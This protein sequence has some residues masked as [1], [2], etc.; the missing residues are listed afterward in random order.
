MPRPR[1]KT[2]QPLTT[3]MTVE[4]SGSVLEAA[5]LKGLQPLYG[6][7]ASLRQESIKQ[8][9]AQSDTQAFLKTLS[10]QVLTL[11]I[12][13]TQLNQTLAKLSEPSKSDNDIGNSLDKLQQ[14]LMQL[15]KGLTVLHIKLDNNSGYQHELAKDLSDLNQPL[16]Q[17]D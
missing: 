10:E 5:L 1:K 7:I 6:E 15:E 8:Q 16:S 9:A 13:Q 17:A 12:Q 11:L 2:T 3:L 4:M 14:C